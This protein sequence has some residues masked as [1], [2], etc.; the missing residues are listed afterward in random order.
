IG[1]GAAS[2]IPALRSFMATKNEHAASR[3]FIDQA[4]FEAA[5]AL[6]SIDPSDTNAIA[7]IREAKSVAGPFNKYG[8]MPRTR[9][10]ASV[11]LWK[12]GLETNPPVDELISWVG[13]DNTG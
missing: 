8:D 5:Q 11:S 2:A 7:I 9:L 3:W 6:A 4:R 1:P 13:R 10:A 12:L